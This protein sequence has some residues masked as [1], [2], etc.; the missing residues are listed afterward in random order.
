MKS[1]NL[2]TYVFALMLLFSTVI[3]SCGSKEMEFNK[4]KWDRQI[5]GIYE[6][7]EMMTTDLIANHLHKGMH[8][9]KIVKMLGAARKLF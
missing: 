4:A 9:D 5:D 7:R 1:S 8:H 3:I 2:L 6:Y